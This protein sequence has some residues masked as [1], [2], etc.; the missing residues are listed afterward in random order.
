MAIMVVLQ[1]PPSESSRMRVSLL[2]RYG[3]C[4]RPR[5]SVSAAMTLPSA[6]SDWLIFFDSS[7][8]WPVAPERRTRSLPAR[9]TRFSLPTLKD[10]FTFDSSALSAAS[11]CARDLTSRWKSSTVISAPESSRYVVSLWRKGGDAVRGNGVMQRNPRACVGRRGYVRTCSAMM[12]KTACE[13]DESS[14]ILVD[15]VARIAPPRSM[16]P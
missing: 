13:R 1:L 11:P 6:E 10:C 3:M 12:M 8:R 14:F 16:R 5:G 2:S 15:P 4:C 7:R 9:S